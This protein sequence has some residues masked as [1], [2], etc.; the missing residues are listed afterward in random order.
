MQMR[1]GPRMLGVAV[2]AMTKIGADCCRY[3]G[4][5]N[6]QPERNCNRMG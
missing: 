2:E 5:R 6:H 4:D 3:C 1:Y